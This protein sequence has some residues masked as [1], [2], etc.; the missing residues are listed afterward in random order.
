MPRTPA[1]MEE[2]RDVWSEFKGL[3]RQLRA[4]EESLQ[5]KRNQVQQAKEQ[6]AMVLAEPE[7]KEFRLLYDKAIRQIQQGEQASGRRIEIAE[8]LQRL[9]TQLASFHQN[10]VRVGQ[11]CEAASDKWKSQCQAIAL[12]EGI[13]SGSGLTLLRERTEILLKFDNWKKLT[14]ELQKTTRA[15]QQYEQAVNDH[16]NALGI[17][18][19]RPKPRS[20]GCGIHSTKGREAQA[21]YNQLAGQIDEAKN[22][23]T[24]VQEIHTQAVQALEAL[25]HMAKLQTV[26]ALEPLLANLDLRDLARCQIA[27]FRD[28]LSG[29]ARNQTVDEFL[30][31]IRAEDIE[32]LA[33]RK[34]MLQHQKNDKE[35]AL[36]AVRDALSEL[37]GRKQVL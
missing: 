3:L 32:A 9:K 18:G 20:P 5:R 6:L 24:G 35:T 36:Q 37:K 26:E 7:E 11:S 14:T 12:P 25:T 19:V 29:L 1:E 4:S 2:W 28:T 16:C 34:V 15:I 17:K 10:S 23:L 21:R 27:T 22:D 8:Q 31:C 13:S 33:R 30:A